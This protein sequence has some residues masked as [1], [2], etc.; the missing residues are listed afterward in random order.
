MEPGRDDEDPVVAIDY[1]FLKL[2]GTVDLDGDGDDEVA[3]E[4][5]FCTLNWK[6]K[7]YEPMAFFWFGTRY[8][9]DNTKVRHSFFGKAAVHV[10]T[11]G[12]W[13]GLERMDHRGVLE[14][15][16]GALGRKTGMKHREFESQIMKKRHLCSQSL[17][18][19]GS[20]CTKVVWR[21]EGERATGSR[22]AWS[23]RTG[24]ED[25][26]LHCP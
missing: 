22:S 4:A 14:W 19:T 12:S 1:G 20:F 9:N 10:V 17:C 18:S 15:D 21:R 2:D 13:L 11:G 25:T 6:R 3:L 16:G 26:V 24:H 8:R 23:G 5:F 7:K